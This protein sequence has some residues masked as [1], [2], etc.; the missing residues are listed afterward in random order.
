MVTDWDNRVTAY[1][2]DAN[3]RLIRAVRPNGTEMTRSYDAAGQLLQQKDVD[4][5]GNT[6]SQYDFTYDAAGNAAE[7]KTAAAPQPFALDNA[8]MTYTSDNRLA[9]YNGQAVAF[10]ADGNMT[11]GPLAG[12]ISNYAYDA[13]NR[14]ISA[15]E[16]TYLND[17]ENQLISVIKDVYQ[18]RYVINPNTPVSQLLI[19]TDN[20][21]N[22]TFYIYGLGLIGQEE[23]GVYR[24]YHFDRRGSTVA[25][26]DNNGIVTDRFQY[27]PYGALVYRSGNTSTPFFYNGRSGVITDSNGLYYTR[28]R[29]YNPEIRRF[30][31]QDVLPGSV[32]NGQ[33][34]NRYAYVNG[35]PVSY[36]DPFGLCAE[37]DNFGAGDA[38]SIAADLTPVAGNVK[39]L[40]QVFTGTDIITGKKESR[41]LSA[42][43]VVPFLG[44]TVK[45][46]KGTI[47]AGEVTTKLVKHHMVPR[48]IFRKFL[49]E[50]VA[51]NPLIRGKK[52]AP[53]KWRIP[54]DLHEEL[55]RGAGGGIYNERWKIKLEEIESITV[56][57]V[58]KIRGQ[59]IK[60]F[61][62]EVYRP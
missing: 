23:T 39:S 43:G 5:S 49:P 59:L 50:E 53:N 42:A 13:R 9:A 17:A 28:T 54:E 26:T 21:N 15:G 48:E 38:A 51:N 47:K 4:Q 2:Y 45:T 22:Q 8:A 24:T 56:D 20:R 57:D 16:T 34:L 55:H 33:S 40:I 41:L 44:N 31:N 14:L 30:I 19:K 52:G 36:I 11:T 3:D 32:G 60:E 46:V 62:L 35:Q 7:E 18:E 29:C 25:L 12:G 27:T 10:D 61:D 6:I 1:E 37:E 58:L